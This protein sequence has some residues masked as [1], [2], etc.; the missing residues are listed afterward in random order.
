MRKGTLPPFEYISAGPLANFTP[1]DDEDSDMPPS[2][3]MGMA[4]EAVIHPTKP[5]KDDDDDMPTLGYASSFLQEKN[6]ATT[7]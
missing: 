7:P 4:R 3:N 6:L 1:Q 2:E 5:Q